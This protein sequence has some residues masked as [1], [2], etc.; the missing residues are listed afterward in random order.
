MAGI[1]NIMSTTSSCQ[2]QHVVVGKWTSPRVKKI[3][4]AKLCVLMGIFGP[5]SGKAPDKKWGD[6]SESS[7][8]TSKSQQLTAAEKFWKTTM[9]SEK[10]ARDCIARARLPKKNLKKLR[11]HVRWQP[12]I[13]VVESA[14]LTLRGFASCYNKTHWHG[15]TQQ[16]SV[17][18]VTTLLPCGIAAGAW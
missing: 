17:N 16:L 2:P 6:C 11:C 5:Q 18:E 12:R 1:H 4:G 13:Y 15:C 9:R 10:C 7:F 14:L 3:S 8:C